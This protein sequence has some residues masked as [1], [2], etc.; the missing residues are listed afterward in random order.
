MENKLESILL[1]SSTLWGFG[2]GMLG[3]LYAVF[4]QEIGGDVFD[5]SW[6]YALY[7]IVMGVGVVVVGKIADTYGHERLLML[8][9]CVGTVAVFGYL[10]VNSIPALLLVQIGVAVS[11]S[12]SEPSWYALYDRYSGDGDHDGYV[13]GLSSGL[14]YVAGGLAIFTGGYIVSRFS[15]DALFIIMGTVLAL[16]TLYQAQ[17]LRSAVQ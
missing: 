10:F 14:W 3:P 2:M 13:W 6:V 7:L 9:S 15:F 4:T 1:Y 5:I 16:S 8:G 17:I 11:T 12:L